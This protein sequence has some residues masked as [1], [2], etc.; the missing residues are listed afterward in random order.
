L[1]LSMGQSLLQNGLFQRGKVTKYVD[2]FSIELSNRFCR[3]I[4]SAFS[5]ERSASANAKQN[6]RV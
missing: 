2:A 1:V 3:W 4:V 6:E 5:F